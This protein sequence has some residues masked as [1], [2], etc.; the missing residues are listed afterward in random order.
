MKAPPRRAAAG[1]S[2][3]TD[4]ETDTPSTAPP[5]GTNTA[6][7]PGVLEARAD[8][9]ARGEARASEE[10]RAEAE[11]GWDA[12]AEGDFVAALFLPGV[13]QTAGAADEIGEDLGAGRVVAGAEVKA[14]AHP[15]ELESVGIVAFQQLAHKGQLMVTH[16]GMGVV[17][18]VV[19]PGLA[20]A[21]RHAAQLRVAAPEFRVHVA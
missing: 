20:G 12:G 6:C 17:Q 15:I 21:P 2:A 19:G 7:A 1:G 14:E 13:E 4:T 3:R 8:G 10:A 16:R 9:D 18:R 11:A 5:R